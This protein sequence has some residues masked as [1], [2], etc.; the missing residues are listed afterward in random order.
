MGR[1]VGRQEI[2]VYVPNT[3]ATATVLYRIDIGGS[4]YSKRVAQRNAYGW[5]AL[6]I[7]DMDGASVTITLRDN[8]ASQH[9]NRDGYGSSSI[10]VDAMAM[11]CVARCSTTQPTPAPTAAPAPQQAT[12]PSAPRGVGVSADDSSVSV[13]WSAPSDDGGAA[14]TGY[15]VD[16]FRGSSRVGRQDVSGS[17]TSVSFSGLDADT[18]YEVRVSA[19]NSEGR[20]P[21]AN[22]DV[23]TDQRSEQRTSLSP[24]GNPNGQ[25]HTVYVHLCSDSSAGYSDVDLQKQV[26]NLNSRGISDFFNKESDGLA[27]FNFVKG[28]IHHKNMEDAT[29]VMEL[30]NRGNRANPHPCHI[31]AK[32]LSETQNRQ[33]LMLIDVNPTRAAWG[34]AMRS[35]DQHADGYTNTGIAFVPTL[36]RFT[37]TLSQGQYDVIV[38]HE[39]GHS[40]FS[41]VHTSDNTINGRHFRGSAPEVQGSLMNWT[42]HGVTGLDDV[43]IFCVNRMRAKWPCDASK[44]DPFLDP[45][46]A[47]VITPPS[48]PQGVSAVAHGERQ[49]RVSW[50]PP[51]NSGSSAIS[52]YLVSYSRPAIGFTGPWAS[53]ATVTGTSHTSRNLRYG[54]TY[55][56]TVTAVNKDGLTGTLA[57]DSAATRNSNSTPPS[58]PRNMTV[59]LVDSNSDSDRIE[60]DIKIRWDPP[61]NTHG[62]P[63]TKYRYCLERGP[64]KSGP[65]AI[66]TTWSKCYDT[67]ENERSIIFNARKCAVYEITVAARN[68]HGWGSRAQY[69][70]RTPGCA[71][72]TIANID[73]DP[74]VGRDD[75]VHIYLEHDKNIAE[76]E[77]AYW[78]LEVN[79]QSK[80][81]E[82]KHGFISVSDFLEAST[83]VCPLRGCEPIRMTSPGSLQDERRKITIEDVKDEKVALLRVSVRSSKPTKGEWS[84][85]YPVGEDALNPSNGASVALFE[86]N[87]GDHHFACNHKINKVARAAYSYW[88]PD[89]SPSIDKAIALYKVL[90]TAGALKNIDIKALAIEIGLSTVEKV[91]TECQSIVKALLTSIPGYEYVEKIANHIR[92]TNNTLIYNLLE[93][94][95]GTLKH[96]GETWVEEDK[97]KIS[98][99]KCGKF[100]QKGQSYP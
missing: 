67:K 83:L 36:N 52:H 49:I 53:T 82:S 25:V 4:R 65:E 41:L 61:S 5:T 12:V 87:D 57:E 31:E 75:D 80:L 39:L 92:C 54:V 40:V 50:S 84:H 58:E 60:D 95:S 78:Y 19:R 68:R 10:G 93:Y 15:R 37:E 27:Q 32:S 21:V 91:L 64:V 63:V 69:M 17:T 77:I 81:D 20:G 97:V 35:T 99:F 24:T 34:Y 98:F 42:F 22:A 55:R 66:S 16:L 46:P 88:Q 96:D 100:Y 6:G 2:Q 38:V 73:H 28:S 62:S 79:D 26:N 70:S 23:R 11:R 9:W 18:A 90:E 89:Y 94:F 43:R 51:S 56:V 33:I 7:Y 47:I 72:I 59:G 30:R 45:E 29:T 74:A 76:Y 44:P 86:N 3:R 8:D 71:T 48:S 14:V 85:G 13:S 1:R